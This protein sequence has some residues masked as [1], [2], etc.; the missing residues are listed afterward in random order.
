MSG[1]VWL[2]THTQTILHLSSLRAILAPHLSRQPSQVVRSPFLPCSRPL[3]TSPLSRTLP[4]SSPSSPDHPPMSHSSYFPPPPMSPWRYPI[5]TLGPLDDGVVPDGSA[6]PLF[7]SAPASLSPFSTAH[8]FYGS[9]KPFA[10][11]MMMHNSFDATTPSQAVPPF[12]N[13]VSSMSA[14]QIQDDSLA[15]IEAAPPHITCSTSTAPYHMDI[16]TRT[17]R[18][19]ARYV[20]TGIQTDEQ[21][22]QK[23]EITQEIAAPS[24]SSDTAHDFTPSP[25]TSPAT[26]D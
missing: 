22:S 19:G 25:S 24:K 2:Q 23:L 9:Q 18:W 14:L 21:P 5:S 10:T 13:L 4:S 7:H 16:P 3:T 1:F 17:R 8:H 26:A 20:D 6:S 12:D 15:L 11:S